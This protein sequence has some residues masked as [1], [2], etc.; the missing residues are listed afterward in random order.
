MPYER[1]TK[2][3]TDTQAEIGKLFRKHGIEDVQW[4]LA[5]SQQK[6]ALS[7]VKIVK[8][9]RKTGDRSTGWKEIVVTPDQQ[10]TVRLTLPLKPEGFERNQ[11]FRVLYWYLKSK[12][13]AIAFSFND[14]TV[15]FNFEREFFGNVVI[16]DY[17]GRPAEAYDAFKRGDVAL[18][19]GDS[20]IA[21]PGGV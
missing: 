9:K 15:F 19:P 2:N 12:L 10:I 4:S 20:V 11:S 14:G 21:L 5:A 8:G 16:Q 17:E 13:E 7:F 6:M 1:T 18:A 3:W